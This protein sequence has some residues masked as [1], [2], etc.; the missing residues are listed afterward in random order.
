MPI[1]TNGS[2]ITLTVAAGQILTVQSDQA[3][4]D[5][6][7]PV[8]TRVGEY[9][10]DTVFGPFTSGGSVK[11][12]SVQGQVFYELGTGQKSYT[13]FDP[14]NVSIGGGTAQNL[15]ISNSVIKQAIA[16]AYKLFIPGS[17][18][19]GSGNAKDLSGKNADA[20]LGPS[21]TQANI[22]ANKG[23]ITTGA[24]V[25]DWV[26]TPVAKATFDLSQS[27]VILAFVA[28]IASGAGSIFF[29]GNG[30]STDQGLYLASD[31]NGKLIA[32]AST[33]SALA[34]SLGTST[35]VIRDGTDHAVMIALD[36]VTKAAYYYVDGV[37]S[38]QKANAFS[39]STAPID[40]FYWGNVPAGSAVAAKFNGLHLVTIAGGLPNNLNL[41][42]A[43]HAA[44]P[45]QWYVDGDFQ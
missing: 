41:L 42:A 26:A 21:A 31:V 2:N 27:S 40:S 9:G 30:N 32:F 25:N 24:T 22:W 6:E 43:K 1:L 14:L 28:N 29:A 15:T 35:A 36:S 13:Q 10:A 44:S 23:Y 11:L 18:F 39:G 37:L 7:N 4:F 20:A 3:T 5:F 8:G 16:N 34:T 38:D 33:S 19:N 12:S 17:Q 45:R